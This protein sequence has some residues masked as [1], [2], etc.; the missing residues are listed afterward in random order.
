MGQR[1]II[2]ILS[3]EIAT[4]KSTLSQKL[5]ESFDFKVLRTRELLK[6]IASEKSKG[7]DYSRSFLQNLGQKLDEDEGGKWV[8]E[9]FQS[10]FQSEFNNSNLYVIDSARTKE[11]IHLFRK[12]YSHSVTHIHLVARPVILEDRFIAR[13]EVQGLTPEQLKNKYVEAKRDKTESDVQTL[14][15]DADLVIDTERCSPEDVLIRVASFFRLLAPT[16]NNLV[17]VVIGGQF[18]S[19]GKGHIVAHL[20][21]EYDCLL[22]VGGPNAGHTVY[23]EPEKH[24]FHLLPS[25]THRNQNA[26]II[27]GPGTIINE[28]RLKLEILKHGVLD[29]T[30]P[31]L[32]ID[33]NAIIITKKDIAYE[34]KLTE[35]IG[36]TGQGVGHSTANNILARL[37]GRDT[38]KAKNSKYLKPFISNTGEIIEKMFRENKKILVEGTQG[39]GLSI[40]HG[41]YPHVTS[42]DTTVSGCLSEA[43]IS[44]RRIRKVIM[45]TRTY[46]I[47]VGG[48]SGPFSSTEISM[49]TIAER[50]GKDVNEL[51]NREKTTT[52]KK[53]RRIA[54]FSWQMFRRACELNSPTDI[55]LT[56]TDYIN[57]QNEFARRYDQ[58]T[59]DTRQLIE[60]IER[61]SGVKVS[62]I[63]N[64]FDYRAI[65]DRRNWK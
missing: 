5:E 42:R 63:G 10:T 11:Q 15:H 33:E 29:E 46:P 4:G 27:L 26:K 8:L 43:G 28:D 53:D 41:L 55:A 34:Q 17:D 44:P 6:S 30:N 62:L 19:E 12:A 45:V 59:P 56:F 38:H 21:P 13:A 64:G 54:E 47:R 39:S 16:A 14:A 24:V 48:N 40:H 20:A 61:C 3:G 9:G 51:I 2:L 7:K 58:L 1:K 18:G 35:H 50:S 31:R 23:E 57:I 65:I 22:R 60:E 52:T 36:S 25:G 49:A 37:K 32:F